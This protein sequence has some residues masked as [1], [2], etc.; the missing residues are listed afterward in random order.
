MGPERWLLAN[1]VEPDRYAERSDTNSSA[2]RAQVPLKRT[3]A[4]RP[5]IG[6]TQTIK[7]KSKATQQSPI[8]LYRKIQKLS[9]G[10]AW[11]GL[12]CPINCMIP[13][14]S[15]APQLSMNQS[16]DSRKRTSGSSNVMQQLVE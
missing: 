16:P 5:S 4:G 8:L 15:A 6:L 11:S 12:S 2:C 13:N 14:K 1:G 9:P 3:E 10:H 7:A